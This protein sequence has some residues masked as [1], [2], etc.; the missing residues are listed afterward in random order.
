MTRHEEIQN[1]YKTLGKEATFYDGIVIDRLWVGHSRFWVI[2]GAEF[3]EIH[4]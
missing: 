4:S 1:A 2:Q 3:R